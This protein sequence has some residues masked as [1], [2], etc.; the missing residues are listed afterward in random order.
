MNIMKRLP[1]LAILAALLAALG[2]ASPI[3]AGQLSGTISLTEPEP[4]S[5][6]VTYAVT[7][8]GARNPYLIWVTQKCYLGSGLVDVQHQAVRWTTVTAARGNRS[9]A[10][11]TAGPFQTSGIHQGS[12]GDTAWTSDH[13]EAYVWE[14]PDLL[15]PISPVLTFTVA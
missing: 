14:Y 10:S 2:L 12:E 7:V 6:D 9:D 5:G 8:Q 11:G 4:V 13:C 15:D 1:L 3:R